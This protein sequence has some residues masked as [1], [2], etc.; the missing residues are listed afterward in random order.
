[1]INKVMIYMNMNMLC[2]KQGKIEKKEAY[3][4]TSISYLLLSSDQWGEWFGRAAV[5]VGTGM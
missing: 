3:Y 4:H 1:M 2:P 5:A